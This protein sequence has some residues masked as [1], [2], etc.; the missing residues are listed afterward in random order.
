ML[1]D[2]LEQSNLLSLLF[3]TYLFILLECFRSR[4]QRQTRL[5]A[6]GHG[7]VSPRFKEALAA[8]LRWVFVPLK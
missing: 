3:D 1:Y 6:W 8:L 4:R 5:P 7:R 2:Y